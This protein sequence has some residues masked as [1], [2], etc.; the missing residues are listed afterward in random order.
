MCACVRAPLPSHLLTD[1]RLLHVPVPVHAAGISL[2][3]DPFPLGRLPE[4]ALPGRVILSSFSEEP[5]CCF[6]R[7]H[8]L[9]I[10]PAV[11]VAP[12]PHVLPTRSLSS[13]LVTAA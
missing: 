4:A 9:V 3:S 5:P 1:T 8:Q 2:T 11:R 7:L 12:S 6:Q 13:P 10:P